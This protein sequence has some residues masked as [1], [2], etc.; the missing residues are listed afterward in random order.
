MDEHHQDVPLADIPLP[1]Q[2][3][4]IAVEDHRFYKHPGVDPIALGRAVVRNIRASGT[5]EGWQHADRSSWRGR[6]SSRTSDRTDASCAEAVLAIMIDAQPQPRRRS[7]ELYLQ[8]H[9]SERGRLWRRD[10]LSLHLFGKPAK[11]LT[12]AECAL[13]AG[14]AL[15]PAA[16]ALTN[17]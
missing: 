12:L 15:S 1:L 16:L 14:L 5:V 17:L 2:Q 7:F 13:I 9:L 6:C 11:Q 4:F 10:D 3:A 8:S